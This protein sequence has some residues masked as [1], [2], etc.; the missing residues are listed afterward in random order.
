MAIERVKQRVK[1]G[2]HNIPKEVIIRRYYAGITNLFNLYLP[3]CDEWII[4]DN[5]LQ[6][7]T[8]VA[9]GNKK[10]N[11]VIENKETWNKLK[12]FYV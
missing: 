3:L 7:P 9:E 11:L 2:G 8:T 5:S 10:N 4:F 12:Q 6:V 1:D